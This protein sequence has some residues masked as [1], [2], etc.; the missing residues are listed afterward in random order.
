MSVRR[1]PDNPIIRPGMDERMVREAK[2]YGYEN[3]NGPSLIRVPSW[4]PAP[5]GKYYL[6]FA[7]HKGTYI[8]LAFA[9]QVEGPWKIYKKG[10]L[11]IEESFFPIDPPTHKIRTSLLDEN[12]P[13]IASPDVQ[14]IDAK[15]EIRMYFHGDA[16]RGYWL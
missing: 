14:V 10:S 16:E 15:R 6:Y 12:V 5:L 1:L 2:E 4:V 13:H 8:R 3:I 9:E 11:H 7:G